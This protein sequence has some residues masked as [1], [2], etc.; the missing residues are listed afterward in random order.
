VSE[1]DKEK[2]SKWKLDAESFTENKESIVGDDD[3]TDT[4]T[5]PIHQSSVGTFEGLTLVLNN[6]ESDMSCPQFE[7]EGTRV[8]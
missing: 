6:D 4:D 2:W 5:V 7:G 1:D 8:S 3:D